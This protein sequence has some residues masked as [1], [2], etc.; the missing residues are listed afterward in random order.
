MTVCSI[1][2]CSPEA[3]SQ[4]KI[5]LLRRS[6]LSLMQRHT[7]HPV[8]E[9][10]ALP[11]Y[12]CMVLMKPAP[13]SS[14]LFIHKVVS[15]LTVYVKSENFFSD[16]SNSVFYIFLQHPEHMEQFFLILQPQLFHNPALLVCNRLWRGL[17]V[18]FLSHHNFKHGPL[19]L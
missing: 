2:Y 8:T 19:C 11:R 4:G 18:I 10:S 3:V 6:P 13:L 7:I 15:L 9:P 12:H 1:F 16:F 17:Q 5:R 14:P